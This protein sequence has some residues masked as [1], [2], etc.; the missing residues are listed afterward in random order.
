MSYN[1]EERIFRI[2][3]YGFVLWKREMKK[4]IEDIAKGRKEYRFYCTLRARSFN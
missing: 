2:S 4:W 1:N 3:Q